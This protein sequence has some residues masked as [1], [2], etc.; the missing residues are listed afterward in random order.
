[1]PDSSSDI[2]VDAKA[3]RDRALALLKNQKTMV[4]AVNMGS[5]PWAAPVYYVY[6]GAG[7]YFFS[8]PR[9]FHIQALEECAQCAGSIYADS[10]RWQDISGLQMTGNVEQI[11]ASVDKLH[12]TSKY[13]A[14]FPFARR[15]LSAEIGKSQ[16]VAQK[17]CLYAFRPLQVHCLDNHMG[18]GRR[19]LVAL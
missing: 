3:Y 9:S 12:I 5:A 6:V 10:N 7:I 1:M 11:R 16:S 15:L 8:S 19:V 17:V 2:P 14:K 18:F 4:L 13:L